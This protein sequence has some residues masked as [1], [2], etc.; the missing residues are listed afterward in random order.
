MTFK[1]LPESMKA[2]I[3][4]GA[5]QAWARQVD[6]LKQLDTTKGFNF[7][8][9]TSSLAREAERKKREAGKRLQE[10]KKRAPS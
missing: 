8:M 4:E 7:S 3:K 5:E 10:M 2:A 9:I 1:G 6:L